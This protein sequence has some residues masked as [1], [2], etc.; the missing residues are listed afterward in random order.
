[1]PTSATP[2]AARVTAPPGPRWPWEQIRLARLLARVPA[3][4]LSL[5]HRRYGPVVRF[6]YPPFRYVAMLGPEA[7]RF[8]L[9][10]RLDLFRWREA[11]AFLV[12]V[13]GETA[14]VVSDG[15]DHRRRRQ[16]VQS[17]FTARR[18]HRHLGIMIEEFAAELARW[19]SGGT[20]DA[21]EALR[22]PIK[23]I[24]VR[25]LFGDQLDRADELGAALDTTIGYVN[26]PV[27]RQ[28]KIDLPGT[29]WHRA[30]AARRRT[31][32]IVNAEI[33]RRRAG[34]GRSD[35]PDV[36]DVLLAAV[37]ENGA[38]AL[39][40]LEVRDQVVS[41]IAASYDTIGSAAAWALHELIANPAVRET[42]RA[43]VTEVVGDERL[44][45][46]AL[47]RMPYLDAVVNETLRKW[48][49]TSVSTRKVTATFEF[50]GVR[51]PAGSMVLYS[52]YVTH[53]MPEL[54][55]EPDRFR[56]ERW[57]EG[58]AAPYS[59]V[60]FG[61]GY[62]RCI[63][64]VFATQQLKVLLVEALRSVELA[65]EYDTLTPFGIPA[66][67]PGEGLPVRVTRPVRLPVA[68]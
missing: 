13:D 17:A 12:P 38:P 9:A 29:R 8:I 6:G 40:D 10:E 62:R 48:P 28:F 61:G 54:W 5:L 23:R 37:D 2:G 66:L 50:A 51:V 43:E 46:E 55:A 34:S 15:D 18:I 41:L 64:F 14:M 65:A 31:D 47:N 3:E 45:V 19:P 33:A 44:T 52:P 67:H 24:T 63:G 22:R 42:A 21:L 1:M 58:K 20:V 25:S 59:F 26:L 27:W 53:R 4:G 35:P 36:L 60:P 11:M 39:S 56:P 7:N 49:P 16:A 68:G 30:K 32:L 57:L